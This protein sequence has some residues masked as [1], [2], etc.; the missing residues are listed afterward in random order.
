MSEL[1]LSIKDIPA[2]GRE[3]SFTDS[4]IWTGPWSEFGLDYVMIVPLR[5]TL[6]VLPQNDG[7]LLRGEVTGVVGVPCD[8]CA[9]QARVEVEQ[10]FDEFEVFPPPREHGSAR[11]KGQA[12]AKKKG[13]KPPVD[14][15]GEEDFSP[16]I[17]EGKNGL[18][19][20]AGSLLWEQFVLALPVKPL[21][22]EDC[23]G[24]CPVCGQNLNQGD[25]ECPKD[26]GDPRLA[27]LRKV[28]LS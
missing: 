1:W 12:P 25:C 26:E 2:E 21:C 24:L 22:S 27:P 15:Q 18:E 9:E 6:L 8:R 14:A 28:R 16:L 20:D 19:F 10:H 17:R 11:P 3:F 7:L 23:K 13:H 4:S 5:A